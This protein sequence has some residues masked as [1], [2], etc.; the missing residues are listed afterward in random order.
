MSG[1]VRCLVPV[2]IMVAIFT[3]SSQSQ[4]IG[5]P[6][7]GDKVAHA[8]VYG[9]LAGSWWWALSPRLPAPIGRAAWTLL[10]TCGYAASDEWHQSFVPGRDASLADLAADVV[11]ALVAT[12]WGWQ[13]MRQSL[14]SAGA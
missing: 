9:V 6:T 4:P 11:G 10:L 1:W 7:G 3:L 8:L 2:V 5:L 14:P 13:R 12:T